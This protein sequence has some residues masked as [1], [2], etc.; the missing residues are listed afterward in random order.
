MDADLIIIAGA[1]LLSNNHVLGDRVR[2]AYKLKGSRIIVIDPAPA[3]LSNLADCH[4][5][6]VPG[7]GRG[8][9]RALSKAWLAT[10]VAGRLRPGV[11]MPRTWSAPSERPASIGREF[12]A[13]AR[14]SARL[15]MWR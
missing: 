4:L 11:S 2:D 10:S 1:D 14:S 5:K 7:Q 9:L 6:V 15:P 13:P 3:A 8:P 12:A